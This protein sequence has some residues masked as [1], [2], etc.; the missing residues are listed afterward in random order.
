MLDQ[1]GPAVRLLL[2]DLAGRLPRPVTRLRL[3]ADQHRCRTHLH[4]LQ[5]GRELE[6]V[7]G[8]D[9]VIVVG[10]GDQSG[11][12]E[13]GVKVVVRRIRVQAPEHRRIVRRT[14]I[15]HPGP[16]DRE[17]VEPQHVHHAHSGQG[18][19]EQ[20]RSL[21]HRRADQQAAVGSAGDRQLAGRC[22]AFVDQVLRRGDEVV[23][24]VL[25]VLQHPRP[26][27]LLAVLAAASQVGLGV[28][29]AQLEPDQT[30]GREARRHADVEAAVA[31][32]VGRV[33]AIERYPLLVRDEHGDPGAVLRPIE[34]LAGLV[35][36]GVE[37]DGGRLEHRRFPGLEIIVKDGRRVEKRGERVEHLRV[38]ALSAEAADGSDRRELDLLHQL[39]VHRVDERPRVGVVQVA[40]DEL[41]VD[42]AD[43]LQHVGFLGDDRAPVRTR[44]SLRVDGDQTV[45]RRVEV[46]QEVKHR[47]VVAD[48]RVAGVEIVEQPDHRAAESRRL[49]VDQIDIVDPVPLVGAVPYAHDPVAAIVRHRDPEA[50]LGLVRPLV[51]QPVLSLRRAD[52]VVVQLLIAVRRLVRLPRLGLRIAAVEEAG[53]VMRPGSP[54]EFDPP[55]VVAEVTARLHV[56]DEELAPVRAAGRRR[57]DHP[58]AVLRKRETADRDRPVLRQLVRVQQDL[59]W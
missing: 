13:V 51:D 38:L 25:L 5:S 3:N 29:A 28:D 48:E 43:V 41:V 21:G 16:S 12:I 35:A 2:D 8:D 54:R 7:T 24:H 46:R 22:V 59:R 23:E 10:R 19:A 52:A 31:V 15:G 42:D 36:A 17:L 1:E 53:P 6:R 39:A 44:R 55:Q 11:R 18:G 34:H 14:V 37:I 47:P 57:V 27:P 50:P 4:L 30:A 56:A 32:E 26:V 58:L 45:A 20:L 9:A 40:G 33:R 49:W